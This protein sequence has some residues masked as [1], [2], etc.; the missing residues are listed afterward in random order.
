MEEQKTK[1]T[2]KTTQKKVSGSNVS[3]IQ[4]GK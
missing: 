1:P 2:R 3:L 4:I